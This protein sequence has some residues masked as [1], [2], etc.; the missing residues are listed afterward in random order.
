MHGSKSKNWVKLNRTVTV[1][2][3]AWF[4]ATQNTRKKGFHLFQKR[5]KHRLRCVRYAC[6][7]ITFQ[8]GNGFSYTCTYSHPFTHHSI[9][10][11]NKLTECSSVQMFSKESLN[12][13]ISND[14]DDSP[15]TSTT[16][17]REWRKKKPKHF[18][19]MCQSTP[20]IVDLDWCTI[21]NN[22]KSTNQW[23]ALM[24]TIVAQ[25]F[26]CTQSNNV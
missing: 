16:N 3:I 21:Q 6:I 18:H 12:I 24:L 20:E 1:C 23:L 7:H 26:L 10:K 4:G 9:K 17:R 5:S 14:D 13:I 25:D 8:L 11:T 22:I 2:K 19:F 15:F